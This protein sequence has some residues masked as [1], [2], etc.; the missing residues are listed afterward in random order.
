MPLFE[1]MDD[2][3]KE[4]VAAFS[5]SG[6]FVIG[7]SLAFVSNVTSG[8]NVLIFVVTKFVCAIISAWVIHLMWRRK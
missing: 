1:S 6:S 4:V 5:L 3:G 7:G 2:K 8:Y